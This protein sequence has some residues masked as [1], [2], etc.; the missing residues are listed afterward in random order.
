MNPL[1]LY[2]DWV[3]K[4]RRKNP[5]DFG[6]SDLMETSGMNPAHRPLD[7]PPCGVFW[8]LVD[9]ISHG[10]RCETCGYSLV[11]NWCAACENAKQA[12]VVDR[13]KAR[14]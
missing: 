10:A 8:F 12:A 9:Q 13:R 7:A 4:A 6:R 3:L 14:D 11:E 1:D 5:R 2:Y